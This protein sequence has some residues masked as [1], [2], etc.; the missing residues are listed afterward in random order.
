MRRRFDQERPQQRPGGHRSEQD[1]GRSWTAPSCRRQARKPGQ[2]IRGCSSSRYGATPRAW[3]RTPGDSSR[4]NPAWPSTGPSLRTGK[5]V[6]PRAGWTTGS[7]RGL[8]YSFRLTHHIKG[9]LASNPYESRPEEFLG[10][11]TESPPAFVDSDSC[12]PVRG[13]THA[14]DQIPFGIFVLVAGTA[15]ASCSFQSPVQGG[16]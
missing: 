12:R 2:W 8:S 11:G 7:G 16:R 13:N 4:R 9:I 3:G 10:S 5:G 14:S 1:R 6:P 15:H